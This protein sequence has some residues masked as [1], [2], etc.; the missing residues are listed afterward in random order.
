MED[1]IKHRMWEKPMLIHG[2]VLK[3][4]CYACPEQYDVYAGD[5]IVAYFRL[6]HGTFRVDVPDYSGETIYTAEP[7]GDGVFMDYERVEY[8]TKA[9]L[10]V[11]EYYL[12]MKWDKEGIW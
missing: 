1:E 11:Q 10:A 8:L 9:I 5:E 12:N 4:T 3:R 2:Y 6:R 7:N